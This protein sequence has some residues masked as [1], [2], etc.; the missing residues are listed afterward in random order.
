MKLS[1]KKKAGTILLV[2][3]AVIITAI[4]IIPLLVILLNSF[5]S[6][7]EI[8]MQMLA[9]PTSLDFTNYIVAWNDGGYAEAYQSS[10]IIGVSTAVAELL[11]IGLAVYGL[12]KT[13]CYFKNFFRS[14]FVA[15]LAIPA[16]AILVPLYFFFSSVGLINSHLGMIII[17]TATNMSF[18][19]MFLSAFF[20]GM[21]KELDEAARIDGANEFY[22]FHKIVLPMSK[23]GI[24]SIAIFQFLWAWEDFLWPYL[25][26]T[27]KDKQL[28]A[29]G[30]KMFNGQYST[31][32]G[33]LFAATAISII[34]VLLIY[35][36]FQKQF[37]AGIAASA[38][39]G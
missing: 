3:I 35:L 22:I 9:F 10:L 24:F 13:N 30:L 36:F 25:V 33:A 26:I 20:E 23:N 14:Y 21:P 27:N 15:G 29:V 32:Y 17:Y 37:I 5:R 38:V 18:N 7:Q 31:D 1:Q 12:T 4:H 8:E 28:L 34:P 11:L 2:S 6:N 39:K 16:F 19:F